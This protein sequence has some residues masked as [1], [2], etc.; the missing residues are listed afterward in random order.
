MKR[1]WRVVPLLLVAFLLVVGATPSLAATTPKLS[2]TVDRQASVAVRTGTAVHLAAKATHAPQ[3]AQIWIGSLST[4]TTLKVEKKCA[5]AAKVCTIGYKQTTARTSSFEAVLVRDES[6]KWVRVTHSRTIKVTWTPPIS[7]FVGTWLGPFPG[8]PSGGSC[9]NTYS[10]I[11]FNSNSTYSDQYGSEYCTTFS[12][13]GNFSVSGS[14]L[15][16]HETGTDCG[17]CQQSFS[18]SVPYSFLNADALDIN[19]YTYYRQSLTPSAG[20]TLRASRGRRRLSAGR[21]SL[22]QSNR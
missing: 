13:W 5:N 15:N 6:G 18:F 12:V 22:P 19:G 9:G 21:R 3:S 1:S 11:I 10:E 17:D 7:E 14:T 16:V 8:E 20:P 4:P 2:L